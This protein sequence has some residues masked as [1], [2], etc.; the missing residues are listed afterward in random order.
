MS[1]FIVSRKANGP[2][3]VP[4]PTLL[5]P[6]LQAPLLGLLTGAR[7][8]RPLDAENDLAVCSS[9]YAISRH[10]VAAVA[11]SVS[12]RSSG[13]ADML[14]PI[15]ASRPCS[16][17]EPSGLCAVRIPRRRKCEQRCANGLA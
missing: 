16:T 13:M 15:A 14:P 10:A 7:R 9:W 3:R 4:D 17:G 12:V 2:P 5:N 8:G 6:R 1:L 11:S